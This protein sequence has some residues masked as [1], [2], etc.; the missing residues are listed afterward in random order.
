MDTMKDISVLIPACNEAG[1]IRQN[2]EILDDFLGKSFRSHEI[3]VAEDGS[4]D[5]T[6]RILKAMADEKRIIHLHSDK[7]L[8]KGKAITNAFFA[9]SGRIILFTDADFPTD[10][11]SMLR[12][13]SLLERHDMVVASRIKKGSISKR[14]LSRRMFSISYNSI[15]RLLFRTGI[16]DHQCG[17]KAFRRDSCAGIFR[18]I[19]SS[20]FFWDTELI[21]RSVKSNLS[22]FEMP[23]AWNERKHGRSKVSI[24]RESWRMG[25]SLI[26]FWY[27]M[28]A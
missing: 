11:K 19:V 3:I 16:R 2:I 28:S 12:M 20:G 6:D 8:G 1:F 13:T 14:S 15:V 17:I 27:Q 9:S 23:I 4:T 21:V 18:Q 22:I 25:K 26:R 5:G 24:C 10:M 7:R